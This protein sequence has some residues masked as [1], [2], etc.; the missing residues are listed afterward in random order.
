MN[1]QRISLFILLCIAYTSCSDNSREG[2]ESLFS[3]HLDNGVVLTIPLNG[4]GGC[5]EQMLSF[6]KKHQ[7]NPAF[8]LIL[9]GDDMKESVY[10][11]K[12]DFEGA[13]NVYSY[14]IPLLEEYSPET[15]Y[16]AYYIVK[17]QKVTDQMKIEYYD[18]HSAQQYILSI[19]KKLE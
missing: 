19:L 15:Q 2:M 4:C 10:V 5:I 13:R 16:P 7:T 11:K 12:R 9:I 14:S 18:L 3:Q 17:N 1:F 8:F 6:A